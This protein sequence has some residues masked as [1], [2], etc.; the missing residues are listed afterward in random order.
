MEQTVLSGRKRSIGADKILSLLATWPRSAEDRARAPAALDARLD[1][2]VPA[3]AATDHRA[4][5]ENNGPRAG[6]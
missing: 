6:A 1:E 5:G 2:N 4:A 3:A